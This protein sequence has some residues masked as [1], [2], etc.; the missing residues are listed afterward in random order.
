MSDSRFTDGV[1][2]RVEIPSVEGP[3]VFRAVLEEA[4]DRGVPVRRVSQGS[5]VMMLTDAEIS[6]L[7]SSA[8]STA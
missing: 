4:S 1:R 6:E 8:R 3:A 5:G 7:A 2:Y